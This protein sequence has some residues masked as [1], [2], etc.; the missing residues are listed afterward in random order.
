[1]GGRQAERACMDDSTFMLA[2]VYSSELVPLSSC[3]HMYG[4]S[5]HVSTVLQIWLVVVRGSW[6][7]I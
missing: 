1:V 5:E 4:S 6:R 7:L 3:L 2:T